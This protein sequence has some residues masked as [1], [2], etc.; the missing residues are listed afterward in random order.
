[1]TVGL[2]RYRLRAYPSPFPLSTR[3]R[4]EAG[5][6]GTIVAHRDSAGLCNVWMSLECALGLAWIKGRDLILVDGSPWPHHPHDPAPLGALFD[7]DGASAYLNLKLVRSYTVDPTRDWVAK[8]GASTASVGCFDEADGDR[9]WV[10]G[11]AHIPAARMF[12]HYKCFFEDLGDAAVEKIGAIVRSSIGP[13]RASRQAAEIL[14]QACAVPVHYHALHVRRGDFAQVSSLVRDLRA[15]DIAESARAA[16]SFYRAAPLVVATDGSDEETEE[17]AE[18]LK[19]NNLQPILLREGHSR[20]PPYL[21]PV[22]DILVCTGAVAF[23]GCPLST[24]STRIIGIRRHSGIYEDT[25]YHVQ[26]ELMSEARIK[27]T[28]WTLV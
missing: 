5:N 7:F 6:K 28:C 11:L 13:S 19:A 9:N 24:F 2:W 12:A 4:D 20:V 16:L 8:K 23:V 22:A 3:A 26:G 17:L 18:A 25:F 1:M 10:L 21:Q 27:P 14:K 15:S